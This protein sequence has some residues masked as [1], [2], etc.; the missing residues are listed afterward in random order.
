MTT[1]EWRQN[2]WC[3]DSRLRSWVRIPPPILEFNS[4]WNA[5]R[6]TVAKPITWTR[7]TK[8]IIIE[9]NSHPRN[10]R[11]KYYHLCLAGW[12]SGYGGWP[13]MSWHDMSWVRVHLERLHFFEI[14]NGVQLAGS[15]IAAIYK[16]QFISNGYVC[17]YVY[18]YLMCFSFWSQNR[19]IL[20]SFWPKSF[21]YAQGIK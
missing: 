13:D 16:T 14:L 3:W 5:T 6:P 9:K 7:Q 17:I 20:G 8:N 1:P 21:Y 15:C 2:V 19:L 12:S 4:L 11:K 10:A 18:I